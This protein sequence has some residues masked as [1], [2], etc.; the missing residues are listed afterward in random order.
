[1]NKKKCEKCGCIYDEELYGGK[2]PLC[3]SEKENLSDFQR[4]RPSFYGPRPVELNPY[5]KSQPTLYGP[6]PVDITQ[7]VSPLNND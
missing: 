5:Q 3:S 2:C 6:P 1:M 4:W 7:T